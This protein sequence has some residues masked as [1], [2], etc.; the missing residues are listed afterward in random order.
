MD[1]DKNSTFLGVYT[2]SINE[3]YWTW[4]WTIFIVSKGLLSYKAKENRN[5]L[6]ISQLS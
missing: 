1:Y 6:M 2:N 4:D 5:L 3:I